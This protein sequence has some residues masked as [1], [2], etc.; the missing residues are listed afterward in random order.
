MTVS[1]AG[2]SNNT[3]D[4]HLLLDN[5]DTTTANNNSYS[6][7]KRM[8]YT[9]IWLIITYT[10]KEFSKFLCIHQ[11]QAGAKTFL[12]ASY[13]YS[14]PDTY[15]DNTILT[16]GTDYLICLFMTYASYKCCTMGLYHGI[17][18]G[19][20]ASAL[21]ACYAISVG[22]GGYA[23]YTF[24]TIDSLNT[25]L[26]KFWWICCVGTVT[27]AGGFMGM[28]CT[29][30]LTF[31]GNMEKRFDLY[32]IVPHSLWWI[33]GI[34]MTWVCIT[35]EISYKRPACDIFVAGTMQFVPTVLCE[36]SLLSLRWK[37]AIPFMEGLSTTISTTTS[38]NDN[39]QQEQQQ[40]PHEITRKVRI[41][42][43]IGFALNAPLLPLYPIYVQYTNLSLG[44][45]NALLHLNLT[46]AWG[47][48]SWSLYQICLAM[49]SMKSTVTIDTSTTTGSKTSIVDNDTIRGVE[50]MEEKKT[51]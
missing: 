18:L 24:R 25:N 28:C 37:D 47:L 22:T 5:D 8:V 6:F 4:Y 34:Y 35:G 42:F 16:Y 1:T 11:S 19:Y 29:D 45:V 27:L 30:I 9:I 49:K 21:F 32:H 36:L 23:H 2:S 39:T 40:Q 7:T 15:F 10:S 44:V 13:T 14:N 41:L 33:Y 51:L 48:Q 43:Y 31:F 26:F 46:V 17:P 3:D 20:K 12:P 38:N 50:K